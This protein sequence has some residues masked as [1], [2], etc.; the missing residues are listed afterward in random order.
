MQRDEEEAL[1]A[2][3]QD[4][5]AFLESSAEKI[6]LTRWEQEV[7]ARV[8]NTSNI[9]RILQDNYSK[10]MLACVV[11]LRT[12]ENLDKCSISS[13]VGAIVKGSL[14]GLEPI[15]GNAFFIKFGS[16]LQ[17][18][19]G[20]R[21]LERLVYE[22]KRY[23][24]ITTRLI[25]KGDEYTLP[26]LDLDRGVIMEWKQNALQ[27]N[28]TDAVAAFACV[29]SNTT[30]RM[31]ETEL[32]TIPEIYQAIRKGGAQGKKVK[33]DHTKTIHD[34]IALGKAYTDYADEMIRNRVASRLI[35][36]LHK[37]PAISEALQLVYEAGSSSLES[38][39]RQNKNESDFIE[40]L[41]K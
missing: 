23:A 34:I 26:H 14:T 21:G 4:N 1:Q 6:E 13:V 30:P 37:T 32:M 5:E 38:E 20:I 33:V 31:I 17:F 28:I 19:P 12:V 27:R 7:F 11:A 22:S 25:M 10:Y 36:R 2:I 29:W 16:R 9:K 24:L 39:T 41:A 8:Q 35:K 3:K 40:A 15:N 18:V